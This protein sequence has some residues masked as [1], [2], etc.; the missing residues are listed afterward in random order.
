MQCIGGSRE[1]DFACTC[2]HS[3]TGSV[4]DYKPAV[5]GGWPVLLYYLLINSVSSG[6]GKS[7]Y[8]AV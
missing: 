4:C 6:N 8:S 5:M 1:N 7:D 2:A 3:S